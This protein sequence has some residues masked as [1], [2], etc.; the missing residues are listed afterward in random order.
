M[1][2][3]RSKAP[4]K[5]WKLPTFIKQMANYSS[6]NLRIEH[7]TI[8]IYIY[9]IKMYKI[10]YIYYLLVGGMSLIQLVLLKCVAI[11]RG[12]INIYFI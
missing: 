7:I 8:Y 2:V 10:L 11:Y 1:F 5:Q 6:N 4:R 9:N 12:S 3:F